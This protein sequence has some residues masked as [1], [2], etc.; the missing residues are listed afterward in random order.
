M[1]AT[2]LGEPAPEVPGYDLHERLGAGASSVVWRATRRTG[3]TEVAVKLVTTWGEGDCAAR[4]AEV[5]HRLPAEGLVRVHEAFSLPDDPGVVAVV[6]DLVEGGSLAALLAARGHLT[7]GEAVTLVTPVART[8]GAL[9]AVG[10]VHADV[11]PGNVLLE[12]SGRPLLADLG[13]ARLVGEAPG[14]MAGTP[15][16]TA[17]EVEAGQQPTTASDVYAVGALAWACVTGEPPAPVGARRPLAELVPSLP[18]AWAEVVTQCLSWR[19][20]ERPT[21]AEVALRL[22]DATPCEPLRLVVGD[23][24]VSLITHR[25]RA[26]APAV[27]QVAVDP[28]RSP[29]WRAARPRWP[30]RPARRRGR[31]SRALLAPLAVAGGLLLVAALVLAGRATGWPEGAQAAET[32]SRA[33]ATPS[34]ATTPT[35]APAAPSAA[36]L[37]TATQD[38]E[39]PRS[40]PA[41]LVQALADLRAEVL[42]SGDDRGLARFDVP[43]SRAWRADATLLHQLLSRGERYE[44]LRFRVRS[45]DLVSSAGERAALRCRVDTSAHSVVSTDGATSR[46]AEQG[47][48]LVLHLRWSDGGWRVDSIVAA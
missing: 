5:L 9:H 4:E 36:G 10:V 11:S 28:P 34:G 20:S 46:P 8:L 30:T 26:A 35:T 3:G 7:A 42:V 22:F 1:E 12:R 33:F 41:D 25:L 19:P 13:V 31:P 21:A 45:A 29:R 32:V 24:E 2:R 40:R 23:D 27:D 15:G 44:G 18:S 17:P 38:R 14:E 43:S 37:S 48:P 39:A 47:A 6:L 16:F